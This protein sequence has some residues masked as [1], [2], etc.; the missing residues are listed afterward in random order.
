M[1]RKRLLIALAVVVC[2]IFNTVPAFAATSLSKDPYIIVV[3]PT[4]NAVMKTGAVLVSVKMTAPRTIKMSF[5]QEKKSG[6]TLITSEKYS[7]SKSLSYYTRHLTGLN[8][9]VYCVNISTLSGAGKVIYA[10]EIYVK[11]QKK[12]SDSVSVDVFNSQDST[13]SFW[14]SLLKKLLG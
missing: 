13:S 2:L 7:S 8:P 14:S 6:H 10:S 1:S 12:T 4:K 9:G 11:V 3:S 5:Y